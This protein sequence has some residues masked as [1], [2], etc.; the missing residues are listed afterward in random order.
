MIAI[1]YTFSAAIGW[2]LLVASQASM[3]PS[4]TAIVVGVVGGLVV[5]RRI[6]LYS[7]CISTF[8]IG[9]TGAWARLSIAVLSVSGWLSTTKRS[10]G[11]LLRDCPRWLSRS[12]R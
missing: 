10:T 4:H 6:P 9:R 11:S 8:G 3:T 1:S 7:W 5:A 2:C 12:W